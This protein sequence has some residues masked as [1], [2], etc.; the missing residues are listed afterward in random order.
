MSESTMAS[1]HHASN[2]AIVSTEASVGQTGKEMSLVGHLEDLRGVVFRCLIALLVG[3]IAVGIFLPF[4]AEALKWP[5]N[6][7]SGGEVSLHTTSVMA[8]FAMALQVCFLGGFGLSLP[9]ML[10]FIARF[11]MPGLNKR[12]RSLL[13]PMCGLIFFLFILGGT[14]S[15]LI[16]VPMSVKAAL[17]FNEK[18]GY[19]E[20]WTADRYYGLL[21]WMVFGVGLMFQLPLVVTALVSIGLVHS[22]QLARF[23]PYS[24]VIFLGLAAVITP[25]TDPFTFLILTLPMVLLY[26]LALRFARRIERKREEEEATA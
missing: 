21:T 2:E 13:R 14:F 8:V 26:E 19:T 20:I 10:Y 5:L 3:C 6:W 9:L 16:L 12:E 1:D 11:V 23:R 4:V 17:F 18:L 7:A 25:T 15:F 24:I 22:Q